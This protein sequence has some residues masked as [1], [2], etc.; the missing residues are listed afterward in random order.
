MPEITV[1]I[2]GRSFDVVCKDGE[3]AFL[4]SAAEMLD[5]EAQ[6]L[7]GAMG[8]MPEGRM[9]LMS[10]LMLA[11]KT[12]SLEDQLI[13]S[14]NSNEDGP[15]TPEVT[16]EVSAEIAQLQGDLK[17]ARANLKTAQD[18]LA[19]KDAELATMTENLTHALEAMERMVSSLEKKGA[20]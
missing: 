8:R 3:E 9:L 4:Q 13:A 5:T 7:V 19:A 12:A 11:D 16:A 20:A 10:G 6:A 18:A 17:A 1:Q 2:G 15:L 14:Q